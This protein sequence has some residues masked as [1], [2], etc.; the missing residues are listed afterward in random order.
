MSNP[1]VCDTCGV[2]MQIGDWPLCPHGKGAPRVDLLDT[3]FEVQHE[4]VT[5][6]VSTLSDIRKIERDSERKAANGEGQQISWRDLSQDRSNRDRNSL[7]EN[8]RQSSPRELMYDSQ[9][10]RRINPKAIREGDR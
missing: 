3:P 10:R 1:W 2:S 5:Y 9:G 6:T 4:G 8:P 7:G